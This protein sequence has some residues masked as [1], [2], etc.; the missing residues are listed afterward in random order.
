MRSGRFQRGQQRAPLVLC[1]GSLP[2]T[3]FEVAAGGLAERLGELMAFGVEPSA[4]G[5]QVFAWP[6]LY[7]QVRQ[8]ALEL[9]QEAR[10]RVHSR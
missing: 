3:G 2:E 8:T 1:Q 10:G 7:L 9:G 4:E 5:F 6:A